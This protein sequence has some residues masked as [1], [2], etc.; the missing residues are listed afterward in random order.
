MAGSSG[1]D[2]AVAVARAGGLGSLPAAMLS[3]DQA[4]QQVEDFRRAVDAPVN[5]NFFCHRPPDVA[6]QD[7]EEWTAAVARFDEELGVERRAAP[8]GAARNPFDEETC[9]VV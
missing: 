7:L 5:L 6:A 9:G 2:L 3:A 4:V 8:P 1:V